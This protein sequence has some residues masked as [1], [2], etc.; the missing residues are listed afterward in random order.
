MTHKRFWSFI[1]SKQQESTGVSPLINKDG[2]LQSD[3]TKKADILKYQ[4]QSVYTRE[5]T[6]YST[7]N[8]PSP[9]PLMEK[10]V[11][12]QKGVTKLPKN[13]KPYKVTGPNSIPA[14]I[15]K[16]AAKEVSPILTRLFI[17]LTRQMQFPMTGEKLLYCHFSRR[18]TSTCHQTTDQCHSPPMPARPWSISST[19]LSRDTL[20]GTRL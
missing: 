15:L 1:K 18:G 19:T 16:S 5:D 13:L 12:T 11:V 9:Y 6:T 4:F 14:Y 10:I 2:F 7:D 8:G 20:V 3:S 17:N